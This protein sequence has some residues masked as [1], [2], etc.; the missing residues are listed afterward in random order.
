M[1]GAGNNTYLI[2]G[3]DS[4]AVLIDAGVGHPDHIEAIAAALADRHARLT[5]VIVTHNHS[6]HASGA[7]ALAARFPDAVFVKYPDAGDARFNVPWTHVDEGHRV[8]VGDDELVVMRTP[9]HAPDHLAVWHERSRSLFVSDLVILGGSV[10]IYASRGGKLAEYLASL[11]RAIVLEP[12]VL[13]PAHGPRIDEPAAVL[14]ATLAHRRAREQ[15]VIAAVEAGR[16]TVQEITES[17]YDQL[18]PEL[19]GVARETVTAHLEKLE[20]E[21]RITSASGRWRI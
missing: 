10:M 14:T 4:T 11:E 6:D 8:A 12:R 18:R 7:P 5:T 20:A 21:G 9:G 15:Q 16:S 13:L 17:I 2:A 19:M 1:T 3:S